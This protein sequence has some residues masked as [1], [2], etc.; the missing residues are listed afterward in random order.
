M[1][2]AGAILH[3]LRTGL[4][5]RVGLLPERT[6]ARAHGPHRS[7]GFCTWSRTAGMGRTRP[8]AQGNGAPPFVAVHADADGAPVTPPSA[9]RVG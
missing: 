8:A 6:A 3:T 9:V 1:Q 2:A 7:G 4:V 5:S